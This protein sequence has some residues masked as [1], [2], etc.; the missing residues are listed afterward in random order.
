M[1]AIPPVVILKSHRKVIEKLEKSFPSS[2]EKKDL[3]TALFMFY[4]CQALTPVNR[5]RFVDYAEKAFHS[6][7][8]KLKN[9]LECGDT[10]DVKIFGSGSLYSI[11]TD[12]VLAV[13]AMASVDNG[14]G[15]RFLTALELLKRVTDDSNKQMVKAQFFDNKEN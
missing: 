13:T 4:V 11:H 10:G 1:V 3:K 2:D 5:V 7:G 8:V 9:I 12:G 6:M 14:S 15:C